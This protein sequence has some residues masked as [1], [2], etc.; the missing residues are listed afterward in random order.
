MRAFVLLMAVLP[1]MAQLAFERASVTLTP[2]GKAGNTI[3]S[4]QGAAEFGARYVTLEFLIE[5]AYGVD[6]SQLS[7]EPVWLKSQQYDVSAKPAGAGGLTYKEM[8]PMLQRLLAERFHL[9]VHREM[10]DVEGYAL[11]VAPG[12]PKLT[13]ASGDSEKKYLL[14]SGLR[15]DGTSLGTF[16]AAVARSASRPVVDKTGLEGKFDIN[17]EFKSFPELKKAM[18]EQLGLRLEAQMVPFEMVVI[19]RVDRTPAGN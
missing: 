6:E 15:F 2:A 18:E 9:A 19:D 1:A 17:L 4:P 12:G 3:L 5:L 8:R 13:A 7:G 16:A 10:K 11:L 14:P